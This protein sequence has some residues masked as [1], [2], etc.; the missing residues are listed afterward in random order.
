MSFNWFRFRSTL[1]VCRVKLLNSNICQECQVRKFYNLY[2]LNLYLLIW[3]RFKD[4]YTKPSLITFALHT[5][6]IS[7]PI[8][9]KFLNMSQLDY[10]LITIFLIL[11]LILILCIV[12]C[13][14]YRRT[15]RSM[16]KKRNKKMGKYFNFFAIEISFM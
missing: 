10:I 15:S 2:L 13:V 3:F 5:T 14:V 12:A 6:T 7:M 1:K 11:L 9:A 8:L 16:K 4:V